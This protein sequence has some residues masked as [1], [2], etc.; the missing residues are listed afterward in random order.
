M[1]GMSISL[2]EV[3]PELWQRFKVQA[4]VEGTTLHALFIRVIGGYLKTA[5][6]K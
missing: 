6:V 3:P 4:A 5:K 2:K 1:A